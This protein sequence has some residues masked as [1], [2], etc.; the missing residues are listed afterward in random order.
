MPTRRRSGPVIVLAVV[1][2]LV[3]SAIAP[4][5]SRAGGVVLVG[6]GDIGDCRTRGDERT[7]R[8]LG[9]VAGTVFT[10]GDHAYTTGSP[11]EFAECYDP[12]WGPHRWRTRP[13]P[14]NH[15]YDTT[16]AAGYF[17]YFGS[18]AGPSG[19]GYFAYSRGSWRIYSLDSERLTDTQ[20][21]W[22]RADLAA[23]PSF[24]SLAY[25]HRP[26]RSSGAHGDDPS[27]KRLWRPLYAAGV[28]IV[29]NGH[30]HNYE[31][32]APMRPGGIRD[33]NGIREFVVGTGGTTLRAFRTIKPN[34][35][36][37]QS[38]VHGVLKLFLADGSYSW[39]F[40]GV[41]GTYTDRGSTPCHGRP[42][43]GTASGAVGSPRRPI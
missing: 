2:I 27:M 21:E 16:D 24:C 36:A 18:K 5:T 26:L 37:R 4:A 42:V 15:D 19:R 32:F 38:S 35:Q 10:T 12:S 1:S 30:D 23:H 22:L 8:L 28:E 29:V 13:S 20:L 31:R 6:A 17:G 41:N 43:T 34:S 3:G 40:I 9:E 39:R 7:G 25:W 11:S 14:G 33:P